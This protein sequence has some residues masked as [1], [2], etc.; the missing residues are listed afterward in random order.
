MTQKLLYGKFLGRL[1]S[2]KA[3]AQGGEPVVSR[4]LDSDATQAEGGSGWEKNLLVVQKPQ[5]AVGHGSCQ[6]M[7]ERRWPLWWLEPA[8]RL[9]HKAKVSQP[10]ASQGDSE[11]VREVWLREQA[12]GH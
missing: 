11:Q 1:S 7:E 3:K 2:G 6:E 12:T 9:S 5:H 8:G 10:L 4:L